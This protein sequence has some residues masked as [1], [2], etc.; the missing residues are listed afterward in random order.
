MIKVVLDA[1]ILISGMFGINLSP[2]RQIINLCVAKQIVIC[3][4]DKTFN[5]F[6]EKVRL[7]R[8]KKYWDK[9][10]FS[11][12]KIIQD[13]RYFVSMV[14]TNGIL[15]SE[16]IVEEDPDDDEYFKVA[17]ASNSKIIITRDSAVLKVKKYNNIIVVPPNRFIESYSKSRNNQL[18]K[19]T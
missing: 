16:R 3:G 15:S 19:N 4:S 6:C 8:L 18:F 7:Q 14:N 2:E 11:S 1:N 12:E 13:Y 17:V 10:L 5:E 9:Q